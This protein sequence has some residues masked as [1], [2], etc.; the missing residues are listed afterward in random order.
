MANIIIDRLKSRYI[1]HILCRT[2][3]P[4][5]GTL[6]SRSSGEKPQV[7]TLPRVPKVESKAG[8]IHIHLKAVLQGITIGASLLP[9]LKAQHKVKSALYQIQC[10][11]SNQGPVVQSV[12]SLTSSLRVISLTVL[13]DS[14]HNI[15]I[16]FAEKM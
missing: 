9:S 1:F 6:D 2:D 13:V 14:I 15:L 7:S 10:F 4:E 12:I 11:Y 16:F 8:T 3:I 5:Y